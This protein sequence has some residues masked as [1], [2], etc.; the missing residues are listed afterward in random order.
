MKAAFLFPGQGAQFVGMG[1]DFYEHYPEAK[2]VFEQTK[3]VL[4]SNFLDM[5]FEGPDNSLQLTENTQ[6]AILTAS[7]AIYQ[8]LEKHLNLKPE[9]MAGL[10]LGEYSAL[11]ASGAISFKDAL[12]LVQKRGVFMQEAVSADDGLMTAIMGLDHKII[13]EICQEASSAGIVSPANYN[14]PGQIVVSGHKEA[15]KFASKLAR[16]AGAKKITDLKVSA[17]FHCA[18]LEP[19]EARLADELERITVNKPD[20]PVVF[21]V[22]AQLE[23][24]PW[25]IKKNLVNQVSSP[26]LWEQSIRNLIESGID[27]FIG[28]GPGN[29][30]SRLMK[31]IA[32]EYRTYAVETIGDIDQILS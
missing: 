12:P 26:I 21:N 9:K 8:V 6:P 32:P 14:C 13:E 5:I 1:R 17:P 29:S 15:V 10:S 11:V 31:R 2:A 18:L 19:V 28:L 24:E 23:S 27:T 3:V 25:Q 20:V 30:L 7:I 22:S 16:E 4:G